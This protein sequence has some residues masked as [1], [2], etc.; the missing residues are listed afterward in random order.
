MFISFL[1]DQT[2]RFLARGRARV[3]LHQSEPQNIE[4]RTAECQKSPRPP[5]EKGEFQVE[6]LRSV[7]YKIDRIHLFKV[8]CWAFDV[9][10]SSFSENLLQ[11]PGE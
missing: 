9:R 5:L 7:F 10:C 3:K 4:Y 6:S 8:R 2:G 1:F 11:S